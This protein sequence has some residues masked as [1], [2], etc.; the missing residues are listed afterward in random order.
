MVSFIGRVLK[1]WA[2]PWF[3]LKLILF[4][5]TSTRKKIKWNPNDFNTTPWYCIV[6]ITAKNKRIKMFLRLMHGF[7]GRSAAVIFMYYVGA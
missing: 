4:N 1:N 3:Y 7:V 6:H 2:I 5:H